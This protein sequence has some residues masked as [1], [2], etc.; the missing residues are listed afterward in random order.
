MTCDACGNRLPGEHYEIVTYKMS[1]HV[2]VAE[3]RARRY[4]TRECLPSG[5]EA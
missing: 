5:V 3:R 2:I 4:C 1:R